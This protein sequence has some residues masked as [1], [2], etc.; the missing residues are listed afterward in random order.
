MRQKLFLNFLVVSLLFQ[1]PY[2]FAQKRTL[3]QYMI[4]GEKENLIGRGILNEEKEIITTTEDYSA[5]GIESN[6][7]FKGIRFQPKESS[8]W[9]LMDKNGKILISP[10]YDKLEV[11]SLSDFPFNVAI[12]SKNNKYGVVDLNNTPLTS[13]EYDKITS[14]CSNYVNDKERYFKV[15]KSN[16]WGLLDKRNWTHILPIAY[17]EIQRF[18]RDSVKIAI[19]KKEGK[20]G[21]INYLGEIIAPAE[22]KKIQSFQYNPIFKRLK[23]YETAEDFKII[24]S[25]GLSA[26]EIKDSLSKENIIYKPYN[27]K[28]TQNWRKRQ[29]EEKKERIISLKV[30]HFTSKGLKPRTLTINYNKKTIKNNHVETSNEYLTKRVNTK[31]EILDVHLGIDSITNEII[32]EKVIVKKD[33]YLGIIQPNGKVLT[34]IIY[35]NIAYYKKNFLLFKDNKEGFANSKG[36]EIFPAQ[37]VGIDVYIDMPGMPTDLITIRTKKYMGSANII[38]RKVYIPEN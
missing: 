34:P 35:D 20:V 22:Y 31:D 1:T 2:L 32:L 27:L 3:Y 9:G 12:V 28:T 37:F 30:V 19:I 14:A 18:S 16:K 7:L 25:W 26:N 38:T 36:Q 10:Q 17:N 21:A 6:G 23:L 8:K 15:K 11:I 33:K 5:V 13:I 24:D 4:L 29:E